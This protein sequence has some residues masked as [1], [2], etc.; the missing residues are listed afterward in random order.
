MGQTVRHLSSLRLYSDRLSMDQA[1]ALV[2]ALTGHKCDGWV[3]DS[4]E[5][6]F[7]AQPPVQELFG[8]FMLH[9]EPTAG[10]QII[11]RSRTG[12]GNPG[13]LL[14][15]LLND[16]F[17]QCHLPGEFLDTP[18]RPCS[19][20]AIA[21]IDSK[22]FILH[23]FVGDIVWICGGTDLD[24][25]DEEDDEDNRI[26]SDTNIDAL[27]EK[28]QSPEMNLLPREH[29]GIFGPFMVLKPKDTV[30]E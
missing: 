26:V 28:L 18:V 8:L 2:E 14:A 13:F 9:L 16:R 30:W 12:A 6:A 29:D 7:L 10:G 24:S 19:D 25:D 3:A 27:F 17:R 1:F 5:N 23:K 22:Y 21:D 4:V 20:A 11:V 15:M